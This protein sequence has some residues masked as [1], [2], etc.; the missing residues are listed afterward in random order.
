MAIERVIIK[1]FKKFKDPFEIRFNE[2]I[3]LLVGDNES[4]KSTILEA[5]H[6]ALMGIY[7]GR[8]I[9]NQLSAYLFNREIVAEYLAS[10]EMRHPIAPPEI[11]IELYFKIFCVFSMWASVL[12][13]LINLMRNMKVCLKHRNSQVYPLSFMKQ[14][15]SLLVE[16]RKCPDSYQY[17]L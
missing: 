14:D 9:R 3:N 16:M 5:I 11:M 13:F 2:N 15:G 6:V 4:G 8:N 17:D 7:A 10:V 12:D 1:N